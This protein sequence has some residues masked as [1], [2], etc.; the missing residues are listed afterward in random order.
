TLVELLAQ[1]AN[2]DLITLDFER[3]PEL[4]ELFASN[5]PSEIIKLLQLQTK[6]DI[7]IGKSLLFFDE[8]QSVAHIILPALRYFYEEMPSLHV[9]ATGSLL[10]FSLAEARYSMPVGRIEYLFLGPLTFEEFLAAL[11][12]RHLLDFLN[13]YQ[14]KDTYPLAIHQRLM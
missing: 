9:I 1:K 13:T 4:A 14:L 3:R 6:R 7:T 10:D 2:L 11:D 8:I 12:E 5:E